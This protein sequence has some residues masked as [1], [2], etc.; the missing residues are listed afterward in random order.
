MEY[1]F[2]QEI[3]PFPEW[4]ERENFH[5]K[6][7]TA[8]HHTTIQAKYRRYNDIVSIL[9]KGNATFEIG[10]NADTVFHYFKERQ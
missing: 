3:S 7:T 9:A 1:P 10:V 6:K 4:Q 2:A 5:Y 8:S